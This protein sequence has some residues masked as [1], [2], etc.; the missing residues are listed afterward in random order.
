MTGER[1]RE[2]ESVVLSQQC[3]QIFKFLKYQS[4]YRGTNA[5]NRNFT[6]SLWQISCA[7]HLRGG[8][9]VHLRLSERDKGQEEECVQTQRSLADTPRRSRT[10]R[11]ACRDICLLAV[12]HGHGDPVMTGR[13]GVKVWPCSYYSPAHMRRKHFKSPDFCLWDTESQV[14]VSFT[15]TK[16][17]TLRLRS[18]RRRLSPRKV[19]P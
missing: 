10:G 12:C 3:L 14:H 16:A 4:C 19:R 9:R 15:G 17:S 11:G 6:V 2:K 8:S 7:E 13:P 1:E 5:E 18:S